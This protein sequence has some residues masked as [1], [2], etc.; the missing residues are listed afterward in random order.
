M[1]KTSVAVESD[2]IRNCD[3]KYKGIPLSMV[4]SK[5]KQRSEEPF[6]GCRPFL[7]IQT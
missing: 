4:R 2:A 1:V 5:L 3:M 6:H 7:V